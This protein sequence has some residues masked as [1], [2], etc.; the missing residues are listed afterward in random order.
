MHAQRDSISFIGLGSKSAAPLFY[1][2]LK[3]HPQIVTPSKAVNFFSD[4]KK[5]TEGI[6]WYEGHFPRPELGQIKGEL[7]GSYL[8]STQAASLIARTYSTAKLMAIIENPLVSVR[9]AYVEALRSRAISPKISLTLFLK[10]NPEVLRE[11]CYGKQLVHYFSYYST[12]DLLVILASDVRDEPL[13]VMKNAFTYLGV[14]PVF[15]PLPIVHLVP[16]EVEDPLKRPGIIKRTIIG[17]KNIFKNAYV[18]FMRRFRTPVIATETA[19]VTARN[20]PLSPELEKYLKDYYRQ[21]VKV[22]SR[23]LSRNLSVEWEMDPE[24][25]EAPK[26][27]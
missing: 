14:D 20:M 12:N 24:V 13:K 26:N 25:P 4:I 23:I 11:A 21:D 17:I 15:V 16:I 8:K 27:A 18:S 10:Q 7:A 5:F 2:Y 9:V 6:D 1:S 3:L 19:S 22:L